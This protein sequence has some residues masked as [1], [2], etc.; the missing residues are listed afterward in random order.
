VIISH[1]KKIVFLEIPKTASMSLRALILKSGFFDESVDKVFGQHTKISHAVDHGILTKAQASEYAVY[2]FIRNPFDRVLSAWN[3]D[4]KANREEVELKADSR[5]ALER[6][7]ITG[8]F[9][10]SP[11]LKHPQT[12]MYE[13]EYNVMPLLYEQYDNELRRVFVL[14]DIPLPSI[15]NVNV[16]RTSESIITR[17][18]ILNEDIRRFIKHKYRNDFAVWNKLN[19]EKNL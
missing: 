19:L 12:D 6:H 2:A 16:R 5:A 1:S 10:R 3:H 8:D 9:I 7:I 14:Y 13:D 17:E 15:P 18:N 11:I 4:A